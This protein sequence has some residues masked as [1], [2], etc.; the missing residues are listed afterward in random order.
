MRYLEKAEIHPEITGSDH[1]PVS[2]IFHSL[3]MLS[4]EKH[5]PL[6]SKSYPQFCGKQHRVTDF[7]Y[8]KSSPSFKTIKSQ[9]NPLPTPKKKPI[10]VKTNLKGSAAAKGKQLSLSHFLVK[11]P[12]LELQSS[13]SLSPSPSPSS[14]ESE[15]SGTDSQNQS[16]VQITALTLGSAEPFDL[17]PSHVEYDLVHKTSKTNSAQAW[18]QL[19]KAPEIPLCKGHNEICTLRTT[20]K[21]GINFGR[22]FWACSRGDGRE[23]DPNANCGYFKWVVNSK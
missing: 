10:S 13:P 1:C 2:A 7:F 18:K 8:R 3:T 19:M 11:K 22:K 14:Q 12:K 15:W 17:S 21:K 16:M 5:P 4:S 9:S 23:K 6:S 20:K